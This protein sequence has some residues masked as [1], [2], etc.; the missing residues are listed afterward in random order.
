MSE[1]KICPFMSRKQHISSS[2][3]GHTQF[4]EVLCQKEKC[5]AWVQIYI[6]CIGSFLLNLF[7]LDINHHYHNKKV[8]KNETTNPKDKKEMA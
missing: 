1:E 5:V 2:V 4:N 7:P 6:C 3:L 8:D